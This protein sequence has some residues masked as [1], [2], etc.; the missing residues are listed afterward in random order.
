MILDELRKNEQIGW[1]FVNKEEAIDGVESGKYYA[2]VI[3]PEDFSQKISSVLTSNI[4]RPVLE[5]YVNEK[6]NA[7]ATKI[8]GKGVE[9][10]QQQINETFINSTSK[11]AGKALN[12]YSTNWDTDK[13]TDRDDAVSTLTDVKTDLDQL[14]D[15]ITMLQS[16]LRTVNSLNGGMKGTLPD[17]S[18]MIDSGGQTAESAKTLIDSS[19]GFSDTMTGGIRDTLDNIS[20]VEESVYESFRESAT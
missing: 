13:E 17:V 9:S 12:K 18:K 7:I 6:K 16:T 3:V 2:A 10:V 15:T 20:Q 14:V 19:R 8:T 1:Q 5:Y 11:V 4:E